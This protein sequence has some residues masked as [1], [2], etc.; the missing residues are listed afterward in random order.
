MKAKS[1]ARCLTLQSRSPRL[2]AAEP[3]APS[4]CPRAGPSASPGAKAERE[5]WPDE[6]LV[7]EMDGPR[8][9]MAGSPRDKGLDPRDAKR[10]KHKMHLGGVSAKA[11]NLEQPKR[12]SRNPSWAGPIQEFLDA[13]EKNQPALCQVPILVATFLSAS[14]VSFC[15]TSPLLQSYC[16]EAPFLC[17]IPFPQRAG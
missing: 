11:W 2:R 14:T 1:F 5:H 10:K 7:L 8:N 12:K 4:C 13:C 6:W 3:P 16:L 17:T 9:N 15:E